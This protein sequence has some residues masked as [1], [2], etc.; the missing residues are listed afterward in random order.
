MDQ[1]VELTNKD[2][3][4]I[5]KGLKGIED[6]EEKDRTDRCLERCKV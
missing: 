4:L 1:E 3:M 5:E 6:E 2:Y